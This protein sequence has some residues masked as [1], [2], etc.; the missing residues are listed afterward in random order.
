MDS[1]KKA[2]VGFGGLIVAALV[3]WWMTGN[4]D[5]ALA[6]YGLNRKPCIETTQFNVPTGNFI[7]GKAQIDT[8]CSQYECK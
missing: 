7:C 2:G 1:E 3:G 5:T 4:F 6:Q 8:F